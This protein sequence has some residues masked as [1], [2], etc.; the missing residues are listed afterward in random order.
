VAGLRPRIEGTT[1]TAGDRITVTLTASPPIGSYDVP[2]V[3]ESR[4]GRTVAWV[5]VVEARGTATLRGRGITS[6]DVDPDHLL[7]VRGERLREAA[8]GSN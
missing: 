8:V 7:P 5:E 3:V 4:R 6:I 1:A 2:L